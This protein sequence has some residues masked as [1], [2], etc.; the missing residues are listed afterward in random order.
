VTLRLRPITLPALA[1]AL[2]GATRTAD[3]AEAKHPS[4][5]AATQ[6]KQA[7]PPR[8]TWHQPVA[9]PVAILPGLVVHGAGHL[10]LGQTRTGLSLL[11]LEG[12]GLGLI[13]LG[14]GLTAVTGATRRFIGPFVLGLVAGGALFTVSTLADIYGVLA[15]KGGTGSPPSILPALET[16]LGFAYVYDPNFSYH[17]FVVP[18]VDL[19]RGHLRLSALG[20]F[21]L[22][23]TNARTRAEL[24]YRFVGPLARDGARAADGS[25]LDAELAVTN[26]SYTAEGFAVTTGEVN[27]EGRLDLAR[28]GPTLRGSFAE[29]G[30]GIAL[31]AHR[32]EGF[33]V[34]ANE[35]LTPRFAFGI[36]LGHTG[37]PRGEATLYYEHRH[38]G[39]AAGLKMHG[40]TS[41]MA[42]HFGLG[43]RLYF[44]PRWGT[45]FDVQAGSAFVSLVSLLFRYGGNP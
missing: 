30:L 45:S 16:Q 42:G 20:F 31:A 33:G 38:D 27:F 18:G 22:D 21:G 35:L 28:I 24:A 6:E 10:A 39:Y 8:Q 36:Y 1:L 25:Y 19:R 37:Y 43:S 26:H 2:L 34:E 23:H 40:L 11:G 13:G 41:G 32:Y 5:E 9:I 44:S 7:A 4:H 14:L 3:A 12:G 29:L 15:P 17:T